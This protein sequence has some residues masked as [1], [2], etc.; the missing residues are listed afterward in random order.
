MGEKVWLSSLK[1]TFSCTG[2]V[3][4]QIPGYEPGDWLFMS[5]R[6]LGFLKS[7]NWLNEDNKSTFQGCYAQKS[8]LHEYKGL[9]IVFYTQ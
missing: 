5:T 4:S 9:R 8:N 3:R 6:R 7:P 1:M 2:T